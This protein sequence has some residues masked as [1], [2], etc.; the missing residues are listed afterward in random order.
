MAVS[1]TAP[2]FYDIPLTEQLR[3]FL[4]AGDETECESLM[5]YTRNGFHPVL[6]GDVLPKGQT[7]VSDKTMQPRYRVLLKLGFGSFATVWLV[8]D[9][10][11]RSVSVRL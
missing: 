6:L 1:T 11:R 10:L 5:G 4:Y 7:C 2:A 9:L 3:H 8:R